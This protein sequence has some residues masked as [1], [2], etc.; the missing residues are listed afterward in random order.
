MGEERTPEALAAAMRSI[1]AAFLLDGRG[2]TLAGATELWLIRHGDCYE[3]LAGDEDPGLSA[4]GRAQ[5]ARL[6][7]RV[8]RLPR[9][10]VYASPLRRAVE[11]ARA[12]TPDVGLD[13]RLVEVRT[14]LHDGYVV[15][16]ESTD[17]V[18]ERMRAAV[19]DIV[20]AH[21]GAR[22]IVVG[23]GVAILGYVCDVLRLEFG[24]LR[25]LPY[26]TSVSIVR[27]LGDRRMVGSL[28]DVGHLEGEVDGA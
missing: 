24:T 9:A 18:L 7:R 14:E 21:P 16:V 4:Q 27:Q 12:I 19:A 6:A 25:L 5:A 3:D 22:V 13:E 15:P 20:A 26:Y 1:E 2:A 23:H 28:G 11:T 17:A 8:R 10:A